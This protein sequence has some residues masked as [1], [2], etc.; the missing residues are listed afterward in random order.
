MQGTE[1]E[2]LFAT[3]EEID[4]GEKYG[5][6]NMRYLTAQEVPEFLIIISK[7][8]SDA[9]KSENTFD[10]V[11]VI[12]STQSGALMNLVSKCVDPTFDMLSVPGMVLT[13]ILIDKFLQMNLE[14]E[15]VKK[16]Q[17][18]MDRFGVKL[19]FMGGA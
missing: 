4:L 13:P 19:G 1:L 18:L 6:V 9:T 8:F 10:M 2:R 14:G 3:T 7:V 5:K 15:T 16:W 17:P 12:V 11:A